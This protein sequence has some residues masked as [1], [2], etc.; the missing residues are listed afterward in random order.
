MAVFTEVPFSDAAALLSRLGAGELLSLTGIPAGIENTNYF[1]VTAERQLV[2]TVFE[3]LSRSELPFYLGLMEH[4]ALRGLPVPRPLA[5]DSGELTH[6][7]SGK[8]AAVTLRLPGAPQLTPTPLQSERV[9]QTLAQLHVAG[10][11]YARQQPN[12]R[13]LAFWEASVPWLAPL[14]PQ[15]SRALLTS[16]LVFQ[17]QLAASTAYTALPRGATHG[18]LFRDN[19]LFENDRLTG[20]LD[21]YFAATDSFLF[22][23]AVCLNDWCGAPDGSLSTERAADFVTA[24]ER[25]RELEELERELIPACLRAA[26][27]R[28]WITRLVDVHRPRDASLLKPH[29]PAQF[30]RILQ[31][32]VAEP[33]QP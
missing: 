25:V 5:A 16:E 7:L 19:V 12:P 11:D 30:E 23:L 15:A 18:D 29:D 24:Y 31:R 8:P 4:L 21:F 33:W 27:L 6:T 13:G 26:A 22:D 14:L 9:A 32:R 17:Q 3:R 10:R 20:L 2:I 1:A 28:F